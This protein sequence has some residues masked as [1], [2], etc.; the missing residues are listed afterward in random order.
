MFVIV[1]LSFLLIRLMPRK[2]FNHPDVPPEVVNMLEA[3]MHLD[4][5]LIVQYMYFLKGIV[6]EG[7][8]GMSVKIRPKYPV[9]DVIKD[10]IPVSMFLNVISLFVS[11]PLGI[12]GGTI[13]ALQRNKLPDHV[14]SFLV[15]M[16]ISIPSFV[17]ASMLQY[18]F[19]FVF[20]IFP[21]L[22][23]PSASTIAE[24]FM[25]ITLPVISLALGPIATVT[26]YLRGELIETLSSEFLLLA[27]T[28]GLSRRQT[29]V[30]HAFRNSCIPLVNII[31]PMF[32]GILGGSLVVE[33]IFA[34]PGLGGLLVK[35]TNA[36][37]HPL[38]VALLIFYS[39]ISLLTILFMDI[40]Y[41][42]LD[43]RIKMGGRK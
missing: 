23:K 4:K 2:I 26:R 9:F 33:S 38:T 41:G 22:Y 17:F 13:A 1:T 8:W 16:F 24:L 7:D 34:V 12:L 37:D 25:S 35:S 32:T 40:I 18:S 36:A 30:R 14:I 39:A 5:P 27:R 15:V 43:P 29:I 3:Q 19:T 28:K 21:T 6:L 11:L 10:R 42:I 20:K 31:V